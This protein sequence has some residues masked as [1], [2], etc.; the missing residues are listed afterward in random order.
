MLTPL[1]PIKHHITLVIQ[2]QDTH[3]LEQL[4]AHLQSQ[5]AELNISKQALKHYAQQGAVWLTKARLK[6]GGEEN[7]SHA[8]PR[9]PE[10]L[11][12]LKNRLHYGDQLDFY[13]APD[14]LHTIPPRPTLMADFE[15][16]SVWIK[17]RGMLSQGSKW[18]DHTALYRWIEMHYQPNHQPRQCWI[19]HRLDRA[20]CGLMLIAHS[21]KMAAQ[22]S[23]LFEQKQIK[24]RYQ[25]N[26]WG[27]FPATPQ[28]FHS[29]VQEKPAISHVQLL[30]S[31]PPPSDSPLQAPKVQ[32]SRIQINIETGRKHQIRTHLSQ[33]GYPIAG[34]RLYGNLELNHIAP[35]LDLQLTADQLEFVCPIKQVMRHFSLTEAQ[36]NLYHQA[37][38]DEPAV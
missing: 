9:K 22:L 20:T 5:H 28:T 36:R 1:P 7:S 24:K 33:A 16:Y 6:R 31:F 35:Q 19:V 14:L 38:L 26:V 32:L 8:N 21:K 11:R 12:R 18:A 13:Y 15:Q 27:T 3:A 30:K 2:Q 29:P 25:A 23:Q 17:P 4:Y 37:L 10:R 34:D